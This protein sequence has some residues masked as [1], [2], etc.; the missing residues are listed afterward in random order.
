MTYTQE[1]LEA[2]ESGPRPGMSIR[3][4]KVWCPD[5]NPNYVEVTYGGDYELIP[6]WHGP[7]KLAGGNCAEGGNR[8][9]DG[10]WAMAYL[11]PE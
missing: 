2:M 3:V 5:M 1:I 8:D 11:R 4:I 9:G 7:F 10:P 6:K